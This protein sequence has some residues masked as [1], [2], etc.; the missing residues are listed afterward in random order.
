MMGSTLPI[1]PELAGLWAS[2]FWVDVFFNEP[3]APEFG[4][5]SST[6]AWAYGSWLDDGL[7]VLQFET[8]RAPWELW[9]IDVII[10]STGAVDESD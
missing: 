6:Y 9:V 2:G 1:P 4:D 5:L 7:T 8:S 3:L 10:D